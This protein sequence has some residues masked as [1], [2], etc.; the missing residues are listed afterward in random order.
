MLMSAS[1][2]YA[3]LLE[4]NVHMKHLFGPRI[5]R[6]CT[7]MALNMN[8]FVGL[9]KLIELNIPLDKFSVGTDHLHFPNEVKESLR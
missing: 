7:T 5:S 6:E 1:A 3:V 9:S 4:L 8:R 2:S